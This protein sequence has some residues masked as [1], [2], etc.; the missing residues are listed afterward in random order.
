TVIGKESWLYGISFHLIKEH[1][2]KLD[3]DPGETLP[4]AYEGQIEE[5][6]ETEP[7]L[8]RVNLRAQPTS[9][10]K[11]PQPRVRRRRIPRIMIILLLIALIF[12]LV[13]LISNLSAS[14][15]QLLVRIGNQGTA[16]VDL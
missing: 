13:H 2:M 1:P 8:K 10:I 11:L 12:A 16:I 4:A 9:P 14:D 15:D 6:E 7:A 5:G 3:N